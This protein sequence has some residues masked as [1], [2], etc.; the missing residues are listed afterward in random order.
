MA[1]KQEEIAQHLVNAFFAA[2]NWLTLL[3]NSLQYCLSAELLF[4]N[5]HWGL[6]G[7]KWLLTNCF[8]F[9]HIYICISV[10]F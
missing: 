3:G 2:D 7:E 6:E 4:H 8:T 10:Y 1:D 5:C 9:W